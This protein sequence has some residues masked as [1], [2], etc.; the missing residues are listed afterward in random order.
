M[1]KYTLYA[2]GEIALVVIGILIALSIN[3]WNDSRRDQG[4]RNDYLQRLKLDLEKDR[5]KLI[6][7][8]AS[9]EYRGI[10]ADTIISLYSNLKVEDT[11]MFQKAL[12]QMFF[13]EKFIAHDNTFKDLTSSGRLDLFTDS[14][15]KF[16]LMELY[17]IYKTIHELEI[18][19]ER[20][21]NEYI[22][23][24]LASSINYHEYLKLPIDELYKEQKKWLKADPRPINGVWLYRGGSRNLGRLF[25]ESI[26]RIVTLDS[27]ISLEYNL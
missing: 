21:L 16:E 18:H 7:L 15:V 6:D 17:S 11:R 10:C 1:R 24:P 4:I 25:S 27:L 2:I 13:N 20:D 8:Q 14:Q 26:S 3:N 19:Y 5:N 23:D 12:N 9:N 22:Y